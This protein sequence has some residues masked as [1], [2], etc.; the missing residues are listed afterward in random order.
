MLP[1][2]SRRMRSWRTWAALVIVGILAAV[3]ARG[4]W[5]EYHLRA[6]RRALQ[7][8]AYPEARAHLGCYLSVWPRSPAA[9][10][11][12]ARCARGVGAF[13]EAE[14][15][16]ADCRKLEADPKAVALE[17]DLLDAQQGTL[18]RAGFERLWSR[19]EQNGPETAAILEALASGCLYTNRLPEAMACLDRWLASAPGD[20]QALYL[21]GLVWEG[22]GI[23]PRAKEDYQEAVRRDPQH[24]PA[25]KRLAE[26][27]L[28]AG[29]LEESGQMFQQ[30][31]ER[32]P[33]DAALLVGLARCRRTQA[34]FD[35]AR[36][37][38]DEVLA[39][40][41]PPPTALVERARLAQQQG[42]CP[43]AEKWFRRALA[44]DAFDDEAW[45]GLGRCLRE[46]GRLAEAKD[47]EDRVAR[48]KKDVE[49]L[50]RLHEQMGKGVKGPEIPCEAG[51]ICLR[52]GQKAEA[53]RWFRNA[54]QWDPSHEGARQG[55]EQSDRE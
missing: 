13:D 34:R 54:L 51:M 10:L 7:R 44:R 38:L 43:A 18:D 15:L 27:L 16:L 19:A 55:L 33:G 21:R 50:H 40:D 53:R 36:R 1:W 29:A 25:R 48:I 49:R 9:H 41:A 30:L 45:Y 39:R 42:D 52:N 17:Q 2:L 23:L 26:Y 11:L 20:S 32:D 31:L 4:L 37:L 28:A 6:A 14:Q 46:L 5:A 24:V 8:R 47:C 12:A 3:A 35:E 22:M